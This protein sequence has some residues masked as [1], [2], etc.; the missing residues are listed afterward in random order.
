MEHPQANLPARNYQDALDQ[1]KQHFPRLPTHLTTQVD[2]AYGLVLKIQQGIQ[3]HLK[4]AEN[5]LQMV[6]TCSQSLGF[7]L[8]EN[9]GSQA[10]LSEQP[11]QDPQHPGATPPQT[12]GLQDLDFED[13]LVMRSSDWFQRSPRVDSDTVRK[14]DTQPCWDSEPRFSQDILTEQLWEIFAGTQDQG[15]RPRHRTTDQTPDHESQEP[16]PRYLGVKVLPKDTLVFLPPTPSPSSSE[17]SREGSPGLGA[18]GQGMSSH[19]AQELARKTYQFLKPICWDPED[20]ENTWNRPDALPWQSRKLAVPHRVEKMQR[21]EHGEPVL[22]TAISSFTRHAFT[23]GRGGVKVWSL[24]GQVTKARFPESFLRVKTPGAYLRTCLLFSDSTALLAGGHNLAGVSL[25]DLTAPSLHVTAELPCAGL[26][27]QALAAS[28]EDSLAFAGFTNG[29]V[30]IWDLRDWSVVRDLPGHPNGAK[31]IAVKDQHVWTGGL[32]ACLRCWDLRATGEPQEYQFESQIM[33]LSPSPH[34]D[35]VLVG[36]ANGQQWLQP[37]L[38]GQKR[39]VGYKDGTILG[40]KFSPVGQWWVSVGTDNLVSIFSM[41]T[42]TMAVQ[43]PERS[44]VMCCDVSPSSHLIVTGSRD[45]ASV[46]QLTY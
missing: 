40:L 14:R 19:M 7:Q 4:Q 27:C 21:L 44:S 20:F 37:S 5:F 15:E 2:L 16:G 26:T 9:Q 33:S 17:G 35:W 41:P 6:E 32:D 30:R 43:V 23:C 1:L 36:T 24:V 11:S 13:V 28:S 10:S 29:S 22:A 3:E 34:E 45:H 39:M 31:S 25:W 18:I 38:G 46:Y 12:S 42:G 8:G